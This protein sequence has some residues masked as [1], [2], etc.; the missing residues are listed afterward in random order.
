[1]TGISGKVV[2]VISAKPSGDDDSFTLLFSINSFFDDFRKK[3]LVDAEVL[4]RAS[5][6]TPLVMKTLA[7]G[8]WME[9]LICITLDIITL[10][11]NTRSLSPR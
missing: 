9:V 6:L 7:E 5:R 10:T 3:W 8:T 2:S 11:T 1:M 4:Q